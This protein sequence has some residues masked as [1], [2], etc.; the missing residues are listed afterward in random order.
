MSQYLF[1]FAWYLR[2]IIELS[3]HIIV[4]SLP[5]RKIVKIV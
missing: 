5:P 3:K 1:V 4:N 2:V